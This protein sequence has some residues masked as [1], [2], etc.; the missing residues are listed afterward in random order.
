VVNA[1]DAKST[2]IELYASTDLGVTFDFVHRVAEGGR[3]GSKA[4]GEPHLLVQYANTVDVTMTYAKSQ[5]VTN[6]LLY[7]ILIS[8]TANIH[9]RF[10][11]SLQPTFMVIGVPPLT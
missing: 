11:N 4:V 3:V 6:A 2:N 9:R 5:P 1:V 7:T 8:V 10:L